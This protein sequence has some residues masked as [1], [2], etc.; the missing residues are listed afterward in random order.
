MDEIESVLGIRSY[1]MNWPIGT[2]GD[3]KGVYDRHSSAVHLFEAGAHGQTMISSNTGKVDDP[4]LA[5]LLGEYYHDKLVSDIELLGGAGDHFD[6]DRVRSGDLTPMFFG[7]AMNNFGVELFL[8]DFLKLA[9]APGVR[10]ASGVEIDPLSEDFSGF[11]FKIQANMNPTHRDRLAFLRICSGKFT[12]AME[13]YHSGSEKVIRL[14]LPQQFM[15]Q[16]RT[17]VEEA[18]PGDIVGIFDPGIFRIGDSLSTGKTPVVFDDIPL[19][20]PENFARISPVDSMKR[21]QFQKGISQLSQEGAIQVYKQPDVGFETL[22]VG[23]V[24]ALQFEVLEHR[25]RGE[26]GVEL[27]IQN[28]PYKLARWLDL[29]AGLNARDLH[30]TSTTMHVLDS[31]GRPM[32]LFENEWSLKWVEDR[33][34]GVKLRDIA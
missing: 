12:K 22:I 20:P 4:I 31:Q 8:A 15:A 7:S 1:P 13:V 21:K 23:A 34:K 28:L 2:D 3:F 30:T 6:F 29:P 17:I 32:L 16:E 11:I 5:D 27:R 24:G 18:W 25:L 19:F 9:P 10:M 14:S 26:Y 33:N